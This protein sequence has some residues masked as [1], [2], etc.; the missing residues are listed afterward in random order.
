[1]E[2]L[3]VLFLW[4]PAPPSSGL[5]GSANLIFIGIA[6]LVMYFFMIRPQSKQRQNQQNFIGGLKKGKK[7]V[8]IGGIHGTIIELDEK[9]VT[10][11]IA[12]KTNV[13]VQRD[14]ISMDLTSSIYGEAKFKEG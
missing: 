11:V 3:E 13:T 14:C 7:V 8:T 4:Q 9:T 10:I 5:G 6:I 12:P 2:F 1:M